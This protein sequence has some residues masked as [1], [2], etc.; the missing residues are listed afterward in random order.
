M[1]TAIKATAIYR[2]R[3]S[4][5]T[6]I[7]GRVTPVV[8]DAVQM[9]ADIVVDEAKALVPVDTGALQDSISAM[10]TDTETS[11]VARI[12]AGMPYAGYVEFGTGR[13]G[14]ASPGAGPYPYDANWPGQRAQP[15]MR[16]A[17]DTS[18]DAVKAAMASTIAIGL[19]K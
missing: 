12:T 3:G 8:H 14:A 6:F 1:N 10:V 11:C 4:A 5:G 13:R 19:K 2:P 16:P 15:Y 7:S 18:R 9:A 17:L